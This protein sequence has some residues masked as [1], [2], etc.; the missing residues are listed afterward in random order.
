MSRKR[1]IRLLISID[2]SW[3]RNIS[4]WRNEYEDQ[5]E[6]RG[7]AGE[8]RQLF[9]NLT[10]NA[11]DATKTGGKLQL[12]VSSQRMTGRMAA[13]AA[14]EYWSPTMAKG[15]AADDMQHIFEPFYTTKKDIGT[16][17]GLWLAHGIVQKH[18]GRI[19]V[20]S[21]TNPGASGTVFS[22]FPAGKANRTVDKT[23]G[24]QSLT[25]S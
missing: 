17:L 11:I 3:S 15:S 8:L 16:G 20:R 2:A 7:F 22:D 14:C 13:I 24:R 25:N 18:G 9:S 5:R 6:I 19:R 1:L 23:G 12:R 10:G 4:K 21:R